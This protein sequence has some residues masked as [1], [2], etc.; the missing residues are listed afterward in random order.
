MS[1]RQAQ[2]M[3][4][5]TSYFHC[6]ALTFREIFNL[7]HLIEQKQIEFENITEVELSVR[8]RPEHNQYVR[9]RAR[10]ARRKRGIE[11][12]DGSLHV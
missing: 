4:V 5:T 6:N 2:V 11:C 3:D 8:R 12:G 7:L 1:R 10:R 9:L